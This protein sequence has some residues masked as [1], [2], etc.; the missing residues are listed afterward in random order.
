[1]HPCLQ[2]LVFLVGLTQLKV[3]AKN[4]ILMVGLRGKAIVPGK[5]LVIFDEIQACGRAVTSLKYFC[6]NKRE[7]HVACAGSLLG[8]AVKRE[9]IAFPVGKI[10]RIRMYPMTFSEFMQ[11]D[12]GKKLYQ[13]LKKIPNER[14]LPELY[15][16]PGEKAL[17]LYYVVGG[18]PEVVQ[19]WV[20]TH[21]LKEVE[22]LQDN[23]LE[24][25][26]SDFSKH[27]P[28]SEVPKL[29]WIWDSVPKQLAKE[30]NKFMF[31]HVKQGKRAKDLE[32]A[33][34][35]L[36]DAGLIYRLEMV[37]KPE[38]PL[39]C[40]ADASYFKIYMSDVG[41]LRR[42]AGVSYHT[43]LERKEE[44]RR[45]RGALTENY[46][47]TELLTLGIKPYF[48]R[49]GNLAE[50]DFLFEDEGRIIPLEAKAEDNTRAKS[51]REFCKRY[52]PEIGFRV[53]LKNVGESH[54]DATKT[55][56]LPLYLIWKLLNYL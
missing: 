8:V 4:V 19:K 39:S 18:M 38:L 13:G 50:V 33:L 28:L 2:S 31:S 34:S 47:L 27:A 24:D 41:L 51:Y 49:S 15:T 52:Q 22:K 42:K 10:D 16:V 35:W 48:W 44:F 26:A 5:T 1:M 45:F 30:N 46:V 7:L 37:E 53:S 36:V 55:L 54:Q 21:D 56:S 23:I 6:E 25:Y 11:A 12:G 20:E 3:R 40:C 14:V 43:I 32:D 9:N 29:G 17:K